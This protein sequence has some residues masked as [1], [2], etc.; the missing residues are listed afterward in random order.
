MAHNSEWFPCFCLP[1]TE[2]TV[3]GNPRLRAK[4]VDPRLIAPKRYCKNFLVW[5]QSD[6]FLFPC[7]TNKSFKNFLSH[8]LHLKHIRSLLYTKEFSNTV[9]TKS[10]SLVTR[11]LCSTEKQ[12]NSHP[13]C[14]YVETI[15]ITSSVCCC[16]SRLNYEVCL[17]Y[18]CSLGLQRQ[19]N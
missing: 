11:V 8:V 17:S 15:I 3:A 12:I 1:Y 7:M 10:Y 14:C 18:S 13:N 16:N 5:F 6:L 19:I 4:F 2:Q 9:I